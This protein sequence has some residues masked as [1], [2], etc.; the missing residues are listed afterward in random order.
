MGWNYRL[1]KHDDKTVWY[2]IH[3]V[4]Y[5]NEDSDELN[6]EEIYLISSDPIDPHGATEEEIKDDLN[7]MF[8]AINKPVIDYN[9]MLEKFKNE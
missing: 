8:E 1:F 7:M 6:E 9:K 5:E 2:G 3:E 4:F